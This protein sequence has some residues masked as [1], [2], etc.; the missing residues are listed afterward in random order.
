MTDEGMFYDTPAF[1]LR[2]DSG[3]LAL[4]RNRVRGGIPEHR[5]F[6]AQQAVEKALKGVLVARNLPYPRTHNIGVLIDKLLG[7]DVAVP[8]EAEDAKGFTKYEALTRYP[9]NFAPADLV[10]SDE[11]CEVAAE[12][13][14]AVLEWAK[15]EIARTAG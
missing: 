13:A 4:V 6:H 12:T 10:V 11:H 2:Q 5:L 8:Q 9:V 7:N 1:W 3:D 14:A 15:A